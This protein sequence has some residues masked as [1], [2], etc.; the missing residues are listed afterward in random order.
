[1]EKLHKGE[2]SCKNRKCSMDKG[3]LDMVEIE[4]LAFNNM[5]IEN[6]D[7]SKGSTTKLHRDGS[8]SKYLQGVSVSRYPRAVLPEEL[9]SRFEISVHTKSKS[10]LN[11]TSYNDQFWRDIPSAEQ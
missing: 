4:N 1:M 2:H 10:I 5:Y 7:I 6:E 8:Y 3:V 11:K 9:K